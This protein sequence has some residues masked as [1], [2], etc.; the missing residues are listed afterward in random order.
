MRAE[1]PDLRALI[2]D[3]RKSSDR[4]I[5]VKAFRKRM[6]QPLPELRRGV[7]ASAVSTLPRTGGLGAWMAR[8]RLGAT[9]RVKMTTV[10]MQVTAGRNSG[11]GKRTQTKM[12][13]RGRVRAPTWGHPV[14]HTQRVT[15]EFFSRPVSGYDWLAVAEQAADDVAEVILYGG[16]ES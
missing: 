3:L 12:V 9:I 14:W 2:R 4:K 1:S 11:S 6:R 16:Q 13:D 15:P 7:R 5:G 10:F 8:A